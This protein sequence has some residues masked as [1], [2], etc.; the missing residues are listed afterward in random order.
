MFNAGWSTS[1]MINGRLDPLTEE[2]LTRLIHELE[3]QLQ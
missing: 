2:R 3:E 1:G